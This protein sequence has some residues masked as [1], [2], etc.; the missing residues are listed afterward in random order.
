VVF[1]SGSSSLP[2]LQNG[3]HYYVCIHAIAETK[4]YE[5]WTEKLPD[6]RGC[7]DGV[8]VDLTSP[9]GGE[10]WVDGLLGEVYQVIA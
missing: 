5:K 6:I 8:T 3:R 4:H 2:A 10:V 9:E 1:G 7:S